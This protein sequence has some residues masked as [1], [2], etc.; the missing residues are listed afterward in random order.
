MHIPAESVVT[1]TVKRFTKDDCK[2][3]QMLFEP[4]NVLPEGLVVIPTAIDSRSHTVPVQVLNLSQEDSCLSPRTR[5]GILSKVECLVNNQC[6]VRFQHITAS[7]EQ[8]T[9]DV[10]ECAHSNLQSILD[11]LDIGGSD[12]QK[13]NS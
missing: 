8:V 3:T 7:I 12:E 5:L 10:N 4:V 1:I 6:E 13:K 2:N 11:K 9:V